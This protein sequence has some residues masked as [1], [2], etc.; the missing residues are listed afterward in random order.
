MFLVAEVDCVVA[1]RGVTGEEGLVRFATDDPP[2]R[3]VAVAVRCVTPDL[4]ALKKALQVI[5]PYFR[6]VLSVVGLGSRVKEEIMRL[7]IL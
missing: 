5:V 2:L 3:P 1:D 6:L 4:S 7:R